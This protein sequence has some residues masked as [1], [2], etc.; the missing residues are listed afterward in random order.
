[1]N[2]KKAECIRNVGNFSKI[3]PFHIIDKKGFDPIITKMYIENGASP[4][5]QALLE[6][7]EELDKKD[8]EDSGKMFKHII[9]T[10]MKSSKYGAKLIAGALVSY[11]MNMSFSPKGRGFSMIDNETLLVTKNENF[12]IL[13]SKNFYNRPVNTKFRKEVLDK[14][15]SR[16]DNI[17]GELVR[18]LILDQGF[19]EGIDVYDVK[20]IHLFEPLVINADEKQAIGRGTRFCGQKGLEF[21]PSLGWQL[22]VFRYD[23]Q[24]PTDKQSKYTEKLSDLYL[25]KLGIDVRK[26]VF[27]SELENTTQGASVDRMLNKSI[28][29]FKVQDGGTVRTSVPPKKIM[30]LKDMNKYIRHFSRFLYPKIKLENKCISGGGANVISFTPSQDFVRHYFQKSSAYKGILLHHSVGTGK[31]CTAIA[32]ATTGFEDYNILW[33]TRHTLKNDIW[34]N[35]FNQVCHMGIREKI[36][37]GLPVSKVSM[38]SKSKL[39]SNKWMNP[40]SYKQFSN[41]LLKKNKIYDEMVKRN[42]KEDPLRKTLLIVDE[43]HKLYAPGVAKSEKP[44]TDILEEMVQKSY[45]VSGNDSVRLLLM[46]ATP[47]TEDG[48]EMIKLLN[49]LRSD[50]FPSDFDNFSEVYLNEHGKFSKK[51]IKK[52]QDKVSG[53]ISYLNRSHDA[54]NFAY[55]IV[56]NVMVDL[57]TEKEKIKEMN[58]FDRMNKTLKN[59]IKEIKSSKKEQDQY[60]KMIVKK[61]LQDNDVYFKQL[62]Q[63]INEN[64]K[65]EMSKCNE[66]STKEKV[67]CRKNTKEVF[68]KQQID[69]KESNEKRKE[70]CKQEIQNITDFEQKLESKYKE[71]DETIKDKNNFKEK[72]NSI[73]T[74]FTQ[75][76]QEI[77]ENRLR[78]ND[79]KEKI[80]E[81]TRQIDN[82]QNNKE[83]L[84]AKKVLKQGILYSQLKEITKNIENYK[85]RVTSLKAEKKVTNVNVNPSKLN[86]ISQEYALEKVCKI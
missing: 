39:L 60:N 54:R 42:G 10:D 20:Y 78:L 71:L 77:S 75:T 52:F 37:N 22:H 45:N 33:V 8:I 48:M 64:Q 2:E 62:K 86:N 41:M 29:E 83:K 61:C 16:P 55:P 57:S 50:K 84:Q 19:K 31:T 40:I 24:I 14:F 65:G 13:L 25:Q 47:Y 17:H 21:H 5:L 69:M 6:K 59:E 34:K 3:Q 82:I 70:D 85:G 27:A 46:T 38:K 43:A 56:Q 7:I 51:G 28:H 26:N 81:K 44:N 66:L 74:K 63:S 23:T 9:F 1:M 73:S 79:I 67:E 58:K 76:R 30:N 11:G 4:K 35:M 53:Y 72:K 18:F 32:T 49:L 36:E 80:L 12:S 68:V 15:N